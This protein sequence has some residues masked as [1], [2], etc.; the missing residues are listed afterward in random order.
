[1]V[2]IPSSLSSSAKRPSRDALLNSAPWA[3]A[4]GF[5]V[6]AHFGWFCPG[7]GDTPTKIEVV[8]TAAPG[9]QVHVVG[10]DAVV[11]PKHRRNTA[12]VGV[13]ALAKKIHRVA[14]THT[15]PRELV[16][17]IYD[18][19]A[20]LAR[21]ARAFPA[22]RNGKTIGF[23]IANT[24]KGSIV[25]LLGLRDGDVIK[26]VNGKPIRTIQDVL[27]A[28]RCVQEKDSVT[29]TIRRGKDKVRKRYLIE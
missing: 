4:L 26:A 22:T 12:A 1:M 14:E 21:N 25:R 2:G 5:A 18:N 19:P 27:D 24:K 10:A 20:L 28:A 3:L 8:T 6:A 23:K 15:V 16:E 7:H 29:I 11:K 13:P 17:R 9:T